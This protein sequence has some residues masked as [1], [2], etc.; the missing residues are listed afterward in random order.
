[1]TNEQVAIKITDL[2]RR[3]VS[4]E[5]RVKDCESA[6]ADITDLV[7]SINKLA[8]SMENMVGEQKRQGVLLSQ[9]SDRLDALEEAPLREF[10][11][12]K[13][14]VIGCILTGIVSF[15]LGN[16]CSLF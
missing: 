10:T 6:S 16:F 14:L 13:R 9:Q 11:Y 15:I 3:M 5:H 12:Y 7:I 8:N 1:M 4:V 2:E